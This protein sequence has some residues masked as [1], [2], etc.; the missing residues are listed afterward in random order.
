MTRWDTA[1]RPCRAGACPWCALPP[2]L[3]YGSSPALRPPPMQ[4]L[5]PRCCRQLGDP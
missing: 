1:C 5:G 2:P 4:E 3:Q